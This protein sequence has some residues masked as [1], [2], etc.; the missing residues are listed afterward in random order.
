MKVGTDGI[1]LGCWTPVRNARRVL[2]A[3][4]GN[5]YVGIMLLQ[6]M[7]ADAR[8]LGIEIEP[9]AAEQ[10]AENY[11]HQPFAGKARAWEGSV[12]DAAEQAGW[13]GH[14][15]L[16][17]SNPPFFRDK[18]KSPIRAR[19]LARHDDTLPMGALVKASAGLLSPGG[20]LCTIWPADREEEWNGWAPGYGFSILQTVRVRTMRH[21]SPKR[22]LSEWVLGEGSSP[23]VTA[24]LILEG[25]AT[26][27][28]TE[29]YLELVRPYLRGT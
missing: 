3:G 29:Q 25:T 11:L 20:R 28:Y 23:G 18:P 14:M 17:I 12:Q 26:L 27:D 4:S 9:S 8:L 13:S 10:S 16:V 6:R 24:E 7:A 21:L 19:N 2:D 1:V 22:I 15:D 5:G